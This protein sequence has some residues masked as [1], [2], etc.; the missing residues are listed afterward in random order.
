MTNEFMAL[1]TLDNVVVEIEKN[2]WSTV[3]KLIFF[4]LAA[5]TQYYVRLRLTDVHTA[6]VLC[7]YYLV[8]YYR[9]LYLDYEYYF[10]VFLVYFL[11]GFIKGFFGFT[12]VLK[13][14][15]AEVRVAATDHNVFTCLFK[16]DV[17]DSLFCLDV[18]HRLMYKTVTDVCSKIVTMAR[19]FMN[20]IDLM[21]NGLVDISRGVKEIVY[22]TKFYWRNSRARMRGTIRRENTWMHPIAMHKSTPRLRDVVD[23]DN[24]R[25]FTSCRNLN[26]FGEVLFNDPKVIRTLDYIGRVYL[27][28]KKHH[29]GY[30]VF[31]GSY[32]LSTVEVTNGGQ[33]IVISPTMICKPL[34]VYTCDGITVYYVGKR[35]NLVVAPYNGAVC[36]ILYFSAIDDERTLTQAYKSNFVCMIEGYYWR[37]GSSDWDVDVDMEELDTL[38]GL[39]VYDGNAVIGL[40][41]LNITDGGIPVVAVTD[42]LVSWMSDHSDVIVTDQMGG[43][44]GMFT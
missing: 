1:F 23:S 15:P 32:F 33:I 39:P 27:G 26:E 18:L 19:G 5:F 20:T 2:A 29:A 44:Y 10:G 42:K 35:S 25:L 3:A 17:D 11:T 4:Y 24:H 36:S 40:V 16:Y 6:R 28:K 13:L 41:R 34:L 8:G 38:R 7:V 21:F 37:F 43:Y 9:N 31:V 14:T 22:N 30:G 12:D